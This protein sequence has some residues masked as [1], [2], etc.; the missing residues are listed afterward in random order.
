MAKKYRVASSLL[1]VNTKKFSLPVLRR[2][3]CKAPVYGPFRR[4]RHHIPQFSFCNIQ[5]VLLK[6]LDVPS[7]HLQSVKVI[8][9]V[10]LDRLC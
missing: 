6:A 3:I 1:T 8:L 9:F 7:V 10:R 5:A 4:I 2:Y